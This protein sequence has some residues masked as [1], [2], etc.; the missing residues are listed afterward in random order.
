MD[1]ICGGHLTAQSSHY[2]I[3]VFEFIKET[4]QKYGSPRE[5]HSV[6]I[7]IIV[8]QPSSKKVENIF[9]WNGIPLGGSIDEAWWMFQ[10]VCG[11]LSSCLFRRKS[12]TFMHFVWVNLAEWIQFT[13]ARFMCG[14]GR[15]F[16]SYHVN[17]FMNA[18]L[19]E[20]YQYQISPIY[21]AA[22]R[23]LRCK[24]DGGKLWLEM[25][26]KILFRFNNWIL[27]AQIQRNNSNFAIS[28]H[29]GYFSAAVTVQSI[30]TSSF[31]E[32]P[33]SHYLQEEWK[34]PFRARMQ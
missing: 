8:Y 27:K 1:A 9:K 34:I 16:H 3:Y 15:R 7:S 30:D 2:F 23:L 19:M 13:A 17:E 28:F 14:I 12:P 22:T 26:M 10:T 6:C 24:F 33:I 5:S 21:D 29:I 18:V 11:K 25:K 32:E 4:K 20:F 31:N